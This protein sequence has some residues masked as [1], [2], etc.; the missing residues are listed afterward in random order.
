MKNPNLF[1]LIP[2]GI[3]SI[4]DVWNRDAADCVV[5]HRAHEQQLVTAPEQRDISG[6]CDS[7]SKFIIESPKCLSVGTKANLPQVAAT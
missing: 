4:G 5:C 1:R 6:S 2:E 7:L 3:T